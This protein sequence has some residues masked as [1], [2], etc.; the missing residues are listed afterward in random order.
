[1]TSVLG[2]A[3]SALSL[4]LMNIS[5]FVMLSAGI[6]VFSESTDNAVGLIYSIWLL[7]LKFIKL[8]IC[9]KMRLYDKADLVLRT[10]SI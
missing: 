9:S 6:Y 3:R 5:S 2:L 10:L 4:L 1:M 7:R 8:M